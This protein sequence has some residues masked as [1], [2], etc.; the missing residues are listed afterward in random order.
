MNNGG[1]LQSEVVRNFKNMIYWFINIYMSHKIYCI[2]FL[3]IFLKVVLMDIN[4]QL[5]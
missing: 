2:I 4:I 3:S 1:S 5:S